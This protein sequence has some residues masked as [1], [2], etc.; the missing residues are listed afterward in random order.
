M[1]KLCNIDM[2]HTALVSNC[3]QKFQAATEPKQKSAT[4]LFQHPT[5]YQQDYRVDGD[6]LNICS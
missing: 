4:S 1:Q 3:T 2:K 6:E 5:N